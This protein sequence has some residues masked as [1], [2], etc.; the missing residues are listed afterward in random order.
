MFTAFL[1]YKL[2][3]LGKRLVKIDKFLQVHKFAMYA[4]IKIPIQKICLSENGF[5]LAVKRIITEI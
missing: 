1:K 3:E 5:A 2:E 4:D